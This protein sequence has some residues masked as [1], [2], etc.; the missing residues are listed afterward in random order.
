VLIAVV[1]GGAGLIGSHA[2][3][4]LIEKDTK[5][6]AG[7]VWRFDGQLSDVTNLLG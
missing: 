1:T 4:K 7:S 2:V 5:V 6:V 3:E